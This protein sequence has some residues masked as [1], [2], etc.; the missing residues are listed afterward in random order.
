[1]QLTEPDDDPAGRDRDAHAREHGA[2]GGRALARVDHRRLILIAG[3]LMGAI[4]QS[5]NGRRS[6]PRIRL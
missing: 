4:L 2:E 6:R 3:M 1:M 5:V